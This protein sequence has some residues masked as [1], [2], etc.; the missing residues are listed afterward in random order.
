MTEILFG[1]PSDSVV[2]NPPASAGDTGLIPRLGRS[3]GEGKGNPLH[4]SIL[5]WKILWTEE[6]GG[7][8]FMGW[9]KSWTQFSN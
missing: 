5:A 3:P 4:S 2:Q 9:Q 7:L 1:F 6:H 8:Q